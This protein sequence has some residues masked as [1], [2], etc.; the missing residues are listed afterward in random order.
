MRIIAGKA[1]R[2]AIKV[3]PAVARPT[4]DFVWIQFFVHTLQNQLQRKRNIALK[5]AALF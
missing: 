4:T 3:P 1:G 2:I 5:S